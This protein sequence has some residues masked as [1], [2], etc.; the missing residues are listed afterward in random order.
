[1]PTATPARWAWM[2]R[3][4]S[5]HLTPHRARVLTARRYGRSRVV[6]ASQLRELRLH[7]APSA[8][9]ER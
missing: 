8:T 7:P 9:G 6:T 4:V 3:D 5:A 1:M 2:V